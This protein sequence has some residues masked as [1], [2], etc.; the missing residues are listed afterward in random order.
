MIRLFFYWLRQIR[1][2]STG[3]HPIFGELNLCVQFYEMINAGCRRRWLAFDIG[4]ILLKLALIGTGKIVKDALEALQQVPQ[5]EC[6]AIFARPHSR[7]KAEALAAEYKIPN[8]YTDYAELL[9]STV[10]DFVYIGLINSAHY[11]Y[12]KQALLAGKNVILEKPFSPLYCETAELAALAE[13]KGCYLFEAV[14]LLH[15]PNFRAIKEALPKLGAIHFV[16]CNYSQYSSRYDD[17]RKGIV[18]PAFDPELYG[19]ALYDI[20]IYNLNF[21]IGLFGPPQETVYTANLG[22]N[23]IDTSGIVTLRYADFIA[24]C[25]GAKDSASPGYLMIQGENGYIRVTSAPNV[26]SAFEIFVQGEKKTLMLNQYEHRMVHEFIEFAKIY[27]QQDFARMKAGL[28]VSKAV[29][30]TAEQAAEYAGL[31]L[32]PK[33]RTEA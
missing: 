1:R 9:Q 4:G 26:L 20:N 25:I 17:Y 18:Q 10:I 3:N 29:I 8:V 28:V 2:V 15:V 21:V 16:Q 7:E 6:V 32:G 23:G 11:V 24:S 31:V 33:K 12:T 22:F 27:E 19:G 14:T 30:Q 5:I 13:E